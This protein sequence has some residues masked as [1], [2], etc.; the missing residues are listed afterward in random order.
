MEKNVDKWQEKQDVHG[1]VQQEFCELNWD[2]A[3]H[4]RLQQCAFISE[5]QKRGKTRGS[6]LREHEMPG[7]EVATSPH[8]WG[9]ALPVLPQQ[10]SHSRSLPSLESLAGLS[11]PVCFL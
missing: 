11:F 3:Q 1:E 2:G 7:L 9:W 8:F 4:E 6:F 5:K 10:A